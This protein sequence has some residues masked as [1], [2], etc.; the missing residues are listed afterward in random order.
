[1]NRM[2]GSLPIRRCEVNAISLLMICTDATTMFV[3]RSGHRLP[4]ATNGMSPP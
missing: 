2:G 4:N 1:M 3:S